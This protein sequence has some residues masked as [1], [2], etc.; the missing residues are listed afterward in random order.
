MI[1]LLALLAIAQNPLQARVD[2]AAPGDTIRVQPGVYRGALRIARRVVLVG[3]RGA[4]IDGNGR[5]SAVTMT[6]DSAELHGLAITNSGRSLD[7]D[8]AALR[9]EGCDYCV[10]QGNRIDRSL[11]GVYLLESHGVRITHNHIVGDSVLEEGRRGNGIHLFNSVG[12]QVSG[13]AI[14]LARDGIYFASA[15]QTLVEDN[16]VSRVRYGLH[17]MYSHDNVFR[18]NTFT[19]NA[20]G[21][22]IMVSRNIRLEENVFAQHVGYRAYGLLLQTAEDITVERNRIEGNLSGL[23][24]DGSVRNTFRGNHIAG[25]GIG[26]DLLASSEQNAFTENAIYD[27]RLSVRKVLGG[28]DNDWAVQGRGNY[29]GTRDV[30]DLNGDG[31]GERRHR[32]GDAFSSLAAARPVLDIFAGTPAARALNWAEEAFPVFGTSRVEDPAPLASLPQPLRM[33]L[34]MLRRST[35]TVK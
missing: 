4:T 7:D 20:A 5:G 24:V 28:G 8:D 34:A 19:R 23:F 30:F 21:A 29:W 13:N 6:A 26:I 3:G 11:H 15:N 14:R 32:V 1:A 27:N 9:L 2:R 35:G 25:N 31:I 18:R 16:V 33:L 22:A 17:Y 12:T 10:V